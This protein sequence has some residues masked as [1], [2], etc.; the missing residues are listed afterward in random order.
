[1]FCLGELLFQ[2]WILK[3]KDEGRRAL[4]DE[5][6][7]LRDDA[8]RMHTDYVILRDSLK[9]ETEQPG[10]RALP[11]GAKIKR[12]L[13]ESDAALAAVGYGEGTEGA[14]AASPPL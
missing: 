5:V 2:T 12:A 1:M 6:S 9:K 7:R 10:V 8:T 14:A 4:E 3:K 13:E 11:F